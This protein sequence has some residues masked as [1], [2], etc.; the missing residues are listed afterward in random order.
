M[1]FLKALVLVLT[2]VM[3]PNTVF[4]Q[5]TYETTNLE[6]TLKAEG[7]KYD[8]KNYKETDDQITIYLFRGN[9]CGYCK[10]FL[11]F[12]NSITDEYGKYFKLQS[13]EVWYN[14]D[15]SKLLE[16]VAEFLDEDAGGVPYIIIGDQVFPGYHE[17][18]DEQIKKAILDLYNSEERYD[19]FVE[20]AKA[21][22]TNNSQTID[23]KPL[24]IISAIGSSAAVV[25]TGIMFFMYMQMKNNNQ[26]LASSLENI[27][28]EIKVL[29]TKEETKKEEK[30]TKQPKKANK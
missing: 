10:K 14:K 21:E 22:Q 30:S 4:A 25:T 6:Q 2:L 11:T 1:K 20:M 8:L 3:M 17:S 12:L 13:Y 27:Q 23:I 9:G 19:V 5:K 18:Y 15:N 7:I 29:K 24:I 26:Q 16:N 28:N